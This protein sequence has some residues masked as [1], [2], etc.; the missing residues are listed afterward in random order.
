MN[1]P[2]SFKTLFSQWCQYHDGPKM[3][4]CRKGEWVSERGKWRERERG[5]E[6]GKRGMD[7]HIHR[8]MRDAEYEKAAHKTVQF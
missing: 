1:L 5:K 4:Q 3:K 7:T 2:L 6:R 8:D